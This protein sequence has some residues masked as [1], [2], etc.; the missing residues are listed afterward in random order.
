M[1]SQIIVLVPQGAEY[2]AVRRGFGKAS[3]LRLYA[4]PMGIAPV[5]RWLRA[6]GLNPGRVIVMGLCGALD[7]QLERGEAVIYRSCRSPEG[8]AW[9]MV[10]PVGGLGTPVTGVTSDRLLTTAQDKA[11]FA[12]LGQVV[13]MEGT[14]ISGFFPGIAVTMA[15]VVSDHAGQDLPNFAIDGEGRL[16][17]WNMALAMVR[18]PRAAL[19][20]IRGSLQALD[21]LEK[22]A[23]GLSSELEELAQSAAKP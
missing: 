3:S 15:R 10:V 22:L 14:A 23:R 18:Q 13:D 17:P 19:A 6:Q 16:K 7:P 9:P 1:D 20:L 12:P 2:Q 11:A 21:Q 4:I 5:T 8:V